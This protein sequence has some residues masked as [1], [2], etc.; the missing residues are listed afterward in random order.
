M[1]EYAESL[2]VHF[3]RIESLKKTALGYQ[4]VNLNYRQL[5]DLELLLNRAFYPLTGYLNRDDYESVLD[6]MRLGD[7]S[8][9]PIPVC[10]DVDEKT[11][12]SLKEGQHFA[13]RD[14]EGF[15]LAV[16]KVGDVWKPDKQREAFSIYGTDDP[17]KHPGVRKFYEETESWY[18]GGDLEGLHFPIHYDFRELRLSPAETHRRFSESGWRNVIAYHTDK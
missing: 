8:V 7:G 9:W 4:S 15:M 6:N 12:E 5:C 17:E 18:V 2:L 11:A 1:N 14:Q 10:L 3:R 16:L 13:L